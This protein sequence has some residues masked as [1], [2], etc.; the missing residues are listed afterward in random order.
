[1]ASFDN[2]T[3]VLTLLVIGMPVLVLGILVQYFLGV[4]WDI[5]PVSYNGTLRDA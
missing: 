1:M 2:A 4:K 3:L 5:F